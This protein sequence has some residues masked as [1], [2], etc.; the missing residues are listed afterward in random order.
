MAREDREAWERLEAEAADE[1]YMQE[2]CRQ[3]PE[4]VEAEQAIFAGTEG[5]EVIT[6]SSDDEV[7]GSKDGGAEG[8]GVIALSSDDEVEGG[9][10]GG[11]EG[12][13]VGPE[14]EEITSTSGGVPSPMMV[15]PRTRLAAHRT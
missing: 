11:A 14:D 2:L 5:G 13:E 10:D 7:E 3:H 12:V 4:L 6:L 1:A 15:L 8:G 9:G